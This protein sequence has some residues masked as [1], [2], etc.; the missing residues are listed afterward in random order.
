MLP[1]D[2]MAIDV[3][4]VNCYECVKFD[5]VDEHSN[6]CIKNYESNYEK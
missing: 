2:G 1:L 6:F 3:I 4:C 5:Y